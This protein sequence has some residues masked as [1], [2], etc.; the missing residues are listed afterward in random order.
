MDRLAGKTILVT[1]AGSGIGRAVAARAAREGAAIFAA[2][3]D[4]SAAQDAAATTAGHGLTLDVTDPEAWKDASRRV[5]ESAGGLD[6]L[7]NCA[8]VDATDDNIVDCSTETWRRTLAVN[9]DG[10]FLGTRTGIGLIGDRGGSIVNIS[11]VLGIVADGETLAYSSSKGAVRGLTKA[12]ALEV[13]A[14]GIRCNTIHPGYVRTPMTRRWLDR[15]EEQGG[16][17]EELERL[18]PLGNLGE[19]ADVASLATYLLSD[20]AAFVT[21]AELAVDGGYLA[22]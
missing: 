12:V 13:A 14:R 4:A 22:V 2:D 19:P 20:E 21:G 5:S 15:L 16:S 1:G 6:G 3:I 9:L 17:S 10:T 11:S 8:G 7:V 18:H